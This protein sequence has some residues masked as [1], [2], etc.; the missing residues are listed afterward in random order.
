MEGVDAVGEGVGEA[1]EVGGKG[2]AVEPEDVVGVDGADGGGDAV[3]EGYKAG[4]LCKQTQALAG[5]C[6]CS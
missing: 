2:V 5:E 3:V 4:V 6:R 1:F